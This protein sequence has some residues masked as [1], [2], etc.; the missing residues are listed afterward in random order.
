MGI[1]WPRMP[2]ARRPNPQRAVAV[3]VV[4]AEQRTVAAGLLGGVDGIA[5]RL[6]C[7]RRPPQL[8]LP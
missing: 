1:K 8:K 3:A 5:Q 6:Q 4:V 2:R 7:D